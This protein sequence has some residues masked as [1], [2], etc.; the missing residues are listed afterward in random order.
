MK[1]SFRLMVADP[2]RALKLAVEA[3]RKSEHHG[4]GLSMILSE[5]WFPLFGI[6]L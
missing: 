5:N 6:M 4:F 1:V 2:G 3:C